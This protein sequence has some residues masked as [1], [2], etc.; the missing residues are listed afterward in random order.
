MAL[1]KGP[2]SIKWGNNPVLDVEEV[3]FEYEVESND[4]KTVDGRR[5]L[6]DNA[7]NNVHC[8]LTKVEALK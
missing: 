7:L 6:L 2:F 3:E 8:R 5:K 1:V 4:Y